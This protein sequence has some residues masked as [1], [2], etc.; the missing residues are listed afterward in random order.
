M[1]TESERL[2]IAR[3]LQD[4]QESWSKLYK[5]YERRL[6]AYVRSS[7]R[8]DMVVEEVVSDTF[9]GFRKSLVNFELDRDLQSWL[10]SIAGNKITDQLRRKGRRAQF[11]AGD[12]ADAFLADTQDRSQRRP[13]EDARSKE[14]REVEEHALGGAL[15][16]LVQEWSREGS[17][18]SIMALELLLV[19][20]EANRDVA[21][22][23]NLEEDQIAA[24]KL[25]AK[26]HLNK[27][28]RAAKLSV[29]VFPELAEVPTTRAS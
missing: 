18:R 26:R 24:I 9:L 19:K 13:S 11:D 3:I 28:L 1:A 20:G 10:F 8:D 14:R 6:A 27:Q 12:R 7:I 21:K 25:R 5:A 29:D 16:R 23:L 22:R 17:Y 2:L 4:D 15:R